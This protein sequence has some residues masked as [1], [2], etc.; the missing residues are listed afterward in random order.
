MA[1]IAAGATTAAAAAVVARALRHDDSGGRG[2][3]D[4]RDDRGSSRGRGDDGNAGAS[5]YRRGGN[6][7]L[8]EV[9][10]NRVQVTY[11]GGWREG[12]L[13]GTFELRDPKGRTVVK[14]PATATDRARLQALS[15]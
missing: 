13:N 10:G 11:P 8:I 6:G 15:R 7:E 4:G 2:R 3:G 9:Q 1:G 12:V 5:S 14:R